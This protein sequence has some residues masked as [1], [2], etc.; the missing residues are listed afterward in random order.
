[1]DGSRPS[2]SNLSQATQTSSSRQVLAL[3]E[4]EQGTYNSPL[5]PKKEAAHIQE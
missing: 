3:L 1:M 5:T 4:W 2:L